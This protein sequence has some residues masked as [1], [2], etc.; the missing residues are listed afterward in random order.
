MKGNVCWWHLHQKD[1]FF[2]YFP[3]FSSL[4]LSS[5]LFSCVVFSSLLFSSLLFYSILI[6]SGY[7]ILFYSNFHEFQ[8][9]LLSTYNRLTCSIWLLPRWYKHLKSSLVWL[10]MR[11][12]QSLIICKTSENSLGLVDIDDKR[13]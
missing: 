8:N 2:F 3:L 9:K 13:P 10:I 6:Y 1:F 7:S 4:V 5:L 12:F 11:R